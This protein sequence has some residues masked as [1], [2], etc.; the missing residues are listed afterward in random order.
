M[1]RAAKY[2]AIWA[3]VPLGEI[4]AL[5]M[6]FVSRTALII[7][8]FPLFLPHRLDRFVR[9]RHCFFVSVRIPE[10][11]NFDDAQSFLNESAI[12]LKEKG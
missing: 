9:Q 4:N 6:T 10:A 5:I 7:Y 1:E 12:N 11:A 8:F 3:Q 2:S